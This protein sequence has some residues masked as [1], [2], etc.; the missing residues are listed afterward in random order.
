MFAIQLICY[1]GGSRSAMG[2]TLAACRASCDK[3]CKL[4]R[5]GT[6]IACTIPY[7]VYKRRAPPDNLLIYDVTVPF[8]IKKSLGLELRLILL[9]EG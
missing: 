6:Y 7:A 8:E 2:E 1:S 4:M 9:E 5:A 3:I